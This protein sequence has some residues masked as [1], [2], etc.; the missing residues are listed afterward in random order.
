MFFV[1]VFFFVAFITV[2]VYGNEQKSKVEGSS[3]LGDTFKDLFN[4]LTLEQRQQIEQIIQ[5]KA[6]TKQQIIDKIKEFAAGIGT[7]TEVCYF[8]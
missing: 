8:Y 7:E 4:G 1:K 5:N 3:E 2:F 6:Y